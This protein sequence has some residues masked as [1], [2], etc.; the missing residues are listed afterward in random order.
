MQVVHGSISYHS[1]TFPIGCKG[2]FGLRPKTYAFIGVEDL[3]VSSMVK[4]HKL[5]LSLSDVGLG[6]FIRQ[7][8]YKSAWF[9]GRMVRVGRFYASSK[10]CS[11]CGHINKELTLSER[12]WTWQ[13]CGIF[14]ERDWN[15]AKNIEQ[16]AL[17]LAC[18]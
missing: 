16:E 3:H 5:A 1:A 10:I 14:H 17:R 11:N 2:C 9:G 4:N 18:A 13:G 15:A 6:E 12:T 8:E 7:I